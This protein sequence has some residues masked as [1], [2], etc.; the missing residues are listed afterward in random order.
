[1]QKSVNGEWPFPLEFK[2]GEVPAMF[3]G[4]TCL[5]ITDHFSNEHE[6]Q[7]S[8]KAQPVTTP[9]RWALTFKNEA[10]NNFLTFNINVQP[11]MECQACPMGMLEDTTATYP[12]ACKNID[13]DK[14]QGQLI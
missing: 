2:D 1:M 11:A 4:M 5:D 14:I 10:T 12:C 6:G 8:L 9:C 7:I 13:Q 3:D